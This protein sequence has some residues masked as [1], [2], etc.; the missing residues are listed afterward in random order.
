M[1]S[2]IGASLA[3]SSAGRKQA[4]Q[5]RATVSAHL[6]VISPEQDADILAIGGFREV[7][8]FYAALTWRGWVARA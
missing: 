5:A 4:W 8:L 1:S 6:L 2:P 3:A 7:A